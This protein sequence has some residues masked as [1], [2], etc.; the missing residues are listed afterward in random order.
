MKTFSMK[1]KSLFLF[2]FFCVSSTLLMAGKPAPQRITSEMTLSDFHAIH[3][4]G[5]VKLYI[6]HQPENSLSA[7]F[8]SSSA[9]DFK[10]EVIEGVLHI[11]MLKSVNRFDMPKVVLNCNAFK[12]LKANGN[13]YIKMEDTFQSPKFMVDALGGGLLNLQIETENLKANIGG[14]VVTAIKGRADDAKIEVEQEAY[15]AALHL[16]VQ[17]LFVSVSG[18]S[19][20][21]VKGSEEV[22]AVAAQNGKIQC[23][24]NAELKSFMHGMGSVEKLPSL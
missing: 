13:Y 20:A 3:V 21:E 9:E 18:M 8:L 24:G 10:V 2:L 23:A 12:E 6:R 11:S 1:T 7:E 4:Q 22:I 15:W 14:Q 19:K 16:D 5:D 17:R